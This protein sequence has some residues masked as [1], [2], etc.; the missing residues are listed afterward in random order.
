MSWDGTTLL[1]ERTA[2]RGVWEVDFDKNK[3]SYIKDTAQ[4]HYEKVLEKLK[5]ILEDPTAIA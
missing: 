5:P 2:S 3:S 4:A 1:S